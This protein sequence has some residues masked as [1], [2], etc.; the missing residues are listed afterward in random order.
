MFEVGLSELL[1]I[2][3][4]ALLVIGPEK[5]P[6]I[7]RLT[8]FWLGK[9]RSTVA[10]IKAEI[11]QEIYADDLRLQTLA[12]ELR[13]GVADSATALGD[14]EAAMDAIGQEKGGD[15][16]AEEVFETQMEPTGR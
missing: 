14:I 2:G 6:K 11:R 5:L 16:L 10:G 7:A 13:R 15:D 4:V 1:M 3:T 9:A 12:A 8:G